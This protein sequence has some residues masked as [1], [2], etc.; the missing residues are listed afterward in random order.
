MIISLEQDADLEAVRRE[1]TARG[2][3]I[4][5]VEHAATSGT[6]HL[7]IA[8]YSAAADPTELA[9]IDGVA[10]V[11]TESA[12]HPRVDAQG[13]V[14]DVR[15]VQIGA[16]HPVFL[17]G[18]CSV[19]SEAQIMSMAERLAAMGVAFLRGGAFKPRTS[20]YA[21]QGHGEVALRWM[22]RAADATGMRMVTEALGEP[23]VPLVAEFADLVQVGSRNMHNYALLK[24]VGRTGRPV[25]LKRGM[26]ATVD[27]WL[28][29][30]E[31][32][33]VHGA[34][35]VVFCER[36]IRGFDGATRNLVDIGSVALL[37]HVHRL[38]VIV[39]PSHGAGRRDLIV[40]LARAA[41]AAGAAG[42]MIETHDDP[43][44]ALSDGPQ[45]LL[46]EMLRD[47]IGTTRVA[48]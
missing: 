25:L 19:E 2:L 20:P 41:L 23:E 45:A 4:S 35:G 11:T 36:G 43:G 39:D 22:R 44:R 27:E 34:S 18:P 26:S 14:V 8:S 9:R 21:F 10:T 30:A 3:W 40:P 38:P 29:S 5:A 33:L 42:V 6:R 7:L 47:L 37:A 17:C 46:P 12:A 48:S 24:A 32:L 1:L 31:Y 13:G 28:L 15:G 16:G